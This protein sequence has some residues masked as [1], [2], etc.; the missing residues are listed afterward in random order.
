MKQALPHAGKPHAW[1]RA[2]DRLTDFFGALAKWALLAACVISGGNA[3][4]RYLAGYSSNAWLEIQWYLFAAG[5]MFGA[6]QVLRHNE[7]VRV[8]LFY[9]RWPARRQVWLDLFGLVFFLLPVMGLMV[10]LSWPLLVEM[11]RSGESSPNAGGL[12]RWPAMLTLPL[13]FLL[14]V[15][16]GLAEIA[17]RVLWLQNRYDMDTHY[18]RPVQ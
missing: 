18:E 6:A 17:K 9:G 10:F 8:D 12:V 16:Q 4:V 3:I 7:H 2:V 5:V 11:V 13:G 1:V 15:L 14:L